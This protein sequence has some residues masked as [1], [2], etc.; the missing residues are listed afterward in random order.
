M[1]ILLIGSGGREHALAWKLKQDGV[2]EIVAAPGNAGIAQ[3]ARCEQVAS[4]DL[5]GIVDLAKREKP[6]L[7]VVGPEVPLAM[8]LADKLADEKIPVFGP[9]A[10][11]ARI[12][13]SKVFAKELMAQEGIPT[14]DFRAIDDYSQLSQFLRGEGKGR[15]WVIKADG[16]AAGKGS[17]VCPDSYKAQ[18]WG[19]EMLVRGR[20]GE[21][22]K[23]VI[24]EEKLEG[25][26]ASVLF[27]CDGENSLPLPIAQDYK[28]AEDGDQGKN[29][30]GMGS[31]APAKHV[32]PE[33]LAEVEQRIV[34]PVL[35]ALRRE[36][37]PF[38]GVLY[39]GLMLT[40]E[41]PKVIEFNCRFGDPE[42]QVILPVW[43]GNLTEALIACTEGRIRDVQK[44][45]PKGAAVCVVLAAEGYPD[46]YEKGIRL[47]LPSKEIG[48]ALVFHAG[49]QVAEHGIVSSGGRVLNA[50]GLG[51]DI[52]RASAKAYALAES[53]KVRG[54]RYRRDI[55]ADG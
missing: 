37:S 34:A 35:S 9:A 14:A 42:T 24:L 22:G 1:K 2:T 17:I 39:V 20:F 3:I 45:E 13:S 46:D 30:G 44:P 28:R 12:E 31:F 54:L 11:A 8:G 50:V 53:L 38:C 27:L 10:K 23:R 49:T 15:P 19:H 55:A 18:F 47:R 4:E 33:L 26:E 51:P 21:A 36:G 48:D 7:V 5:A 41:G 29:T 25:R 43:P 16:L 40:T 52:A 6:D 32:T